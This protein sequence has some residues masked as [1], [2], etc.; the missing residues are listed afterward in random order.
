MFPIIMLVIS[1][2][3]SRT[4]SSMDGLPGFRSVPIMRAQITLA[5]TGVQQN[6]PDPPQSPVIPTREM[7]PSSGTLVP[8]ASP[9][10]STS[11]PSI[12][13]NTSV[14]ESTILR[15]RMS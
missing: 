7:I 11:I 4:S 3:T 14:A 6:T 13:E 8:T 10:D 15:N 5:S 9:V 1:A 12:V 2:T